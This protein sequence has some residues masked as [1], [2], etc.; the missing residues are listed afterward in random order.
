MELGLPLTVESPGFMISAVALQ[1]IEVSGDLEME[2][3]FSVVTYGEAGEC[4]SP[5]SCSPLAIINPT[6]LPTSM[7]VLGESVCASQEEF[8]QWVKKHYRGFCKLVG[9]P[10][11]THEEQCMALLQS[12]EAERIKYKNSGKMKQSGASVKKG[13]RELRNLAS[14]INYDGCRVGC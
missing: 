8:S 5:L 7:A 6:E 14:S 13:A 2:N 10:L 12:I 11:D 1:V 9:F 4:S 3:T